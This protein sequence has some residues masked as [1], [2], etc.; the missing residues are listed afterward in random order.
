MDK[1]II[2]IKSILKDKEHIKF[3]DLICFEYL[4]R[5]KKKEKHS[6]KVKSVPTIISFD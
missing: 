2:E 1:T 6:I 3:F 5:L 4:K